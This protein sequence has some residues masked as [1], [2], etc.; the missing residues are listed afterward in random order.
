MKLLSQTTEFYTQSL[1]LVY[2]KTIVF[3]K[4][5]AVVK[6]MLFSF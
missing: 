3:F 4:K 5:I 6:K 2:V 1:P